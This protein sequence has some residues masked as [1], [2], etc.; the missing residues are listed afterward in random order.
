LILTQVNSSYIALMVLARGDF[1]A[2]RGSDDSYY[3]AF[4]NLLTELHRYN[5]NFAA[6][7]QSD[8]PLICP[9]REQAK[10]IGKVFFP[11]YF[12]SIPP[13][14]R[15][16]TPETLKFG[17]Q[18]NLA[19]L[20][21]ARWL[22]SEKKKRKD[23]IATYRGYVP[24][25]ERKI[26]RGASRI[27]KRK[28]RAFTDY[29]SSGDLANRGLLDDEEISWLIQ[30]CA[31]EGDEKLPFTH[32]RR[33]QRLGNVTLAAL[34]TNKHFQTGESFQ[35]K[36]RAA[37][38]QNKSCFEW[39]IK[40]ASA[41][42]VS[43]CP[44]TTLDQ[45]GK[46]TRFARGGTS[47]LYRTKWHEQD[48]AVK[49]FNDDEK[50][51]NILQEISLMCLLRHA[52]LLP[53]F[54][55]GVSESDEGKRMFSVSPYCSRGS[56]YHVIHDSPGQFDFGRRIK[57]ILQTGAGV[58][59]IHSLGLIHRDLKSLNILVCEDW[60][61]YVADI[62]ATRIAS[63]LMTANVGTPIWM[64]PEV[65]TSQDYSQKADIYSFGMVLFEVITG[66]LPFENISSY[67][68]PSLITKGQRPTFP[69]KIA[70]P[71]MKLVTSMWADKP[72]K[73]PSIDKVLETVTQLS[74]V[75]FT[76][77]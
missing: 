59:Y 16:R 53:I 20:S 22:S 6:G 43:F 7:K 63:Q 66:K 26:E 4:R 30:A 58:R 45:M 55:Y 1:T 76:K 77:G 42:S 21:F 50:P 60:N 24:S 13:N 64:A 29:L 72:S 67:E 14:S 36:L 54:A 48:V 33:L 25:L 18:V 31:F 71:W 46:L 8:L 39:I 19:F 17:F 44:L 12:P 34:L 65:F 2:Y 40:I 23:V 70:K 32:D 38:V 11:V 75:P 5:E 27:I 69:E 57:V 74:T 37:L 62:G 41:G 61:I 28:Q 47:S 56:L 15:N 73:R 52:H 49:L 10:L 51:S 68:L 35:I 9:S 3:S